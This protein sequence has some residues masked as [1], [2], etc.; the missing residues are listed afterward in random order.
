MGEKQK[1]V[2]PP[3][4]NRI[5]DKDLER[6][7]RDGLGRL[8][9]PNRKEAERLERVFGK[10]WN[11]FYTDCVKDGTPILTV[12]FIWNG[13]T[14]TGD[15]A[16]PNDAIF[17][18]WENHAGI[19]IEKAAFL[20]DD[21]YL[22]FL[23]LHELAHL[24]MGGGD[25]EA[26]S[27]DFE[28]QLQYLLSVYNDA[29]GTHLENDFAGYKEECSLKRDQQRADSAPVPASWVE[30]FKKAPTESKESRSTKKRKV[31]V[32]GDSAQKRKVAISD[33]SAQKA[34]RD[35]IRRMQQQETEPKTSQKSKVRKSYNGVRRG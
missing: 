34:R 16:P 9:T 2:A 12:L 13:E 15:F 29:Y 28:N 22:A 6:M 5:P 27:A 4:L 33:D 17:C 3:Q 10:V 11:L 1:R 30:L 32:S 31:A 21:D 26:H 35:M 8:Y 23:F 19:G 14:S 24:R 7:E 20:H 18:G 25:G